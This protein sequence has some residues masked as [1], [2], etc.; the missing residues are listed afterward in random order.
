MVMRIRAAMKDDDLA[1]L[2]GT[3]EVDET[4]MGGK[5]HNRHWDKKQGGRGTAGKIPVIGPIS[6]NGNIVCKMIENTDTETLTRFVR[7]TVSDKVNLVATDEHSVI[8]ISS[9]RC[10]M[11]GQA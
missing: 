5:E 7:D 2:P 10:R 8:A 6:R 9:G 11:K 3:V 1:K 4:Y